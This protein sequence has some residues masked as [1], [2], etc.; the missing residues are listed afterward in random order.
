MK[1]II[2]GGRDYRLTRNGVAALDAIYDAVPLT[3][4]VSGCARGIDTAGERWA[5]LRDLR[6]KRFPADWVKYGRSAGFKRNAQMAEYADALV[7]FP[8]GNGSRSMRHCARQAQLVV[9]DYL[10]RDDFV[11]SS[12][13]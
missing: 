8:G 13:G 11:W 3:E 4:V 9:F 2:A 7:I 12:M 5:A 1:L 6:I 10:H